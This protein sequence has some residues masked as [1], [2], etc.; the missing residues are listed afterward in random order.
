[1]GASFFIIE[2]NLADVELLAEACREV[3]FAVDWTMASDGVAALEKLAQVVPGAEPRLILL[4][5]NL[6]KLKGAE[7]LVRLKAMPQLAKVPVV[8]LSSSSSPVDRARCALADAF[9]AKSATW[10][11]FL[12][13]ARDLQRFAETGVIARANRS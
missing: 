12:D 7:V 8:I 10:D 1:M 4:D 11:E 6:P 9:Y 3:G 2:D 5:L 13:L